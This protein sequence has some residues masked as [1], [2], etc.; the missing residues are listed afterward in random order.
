MK[1]K[2]FSFK[3]GIHP[4]YYKEFTKEKEIEKIEAPS[5][6]EIPLVQ[7]IGAPAE[8]L[9]K[10]GDVVKMGQMI[11][12]CSGVVSSN[13]HASVSGKVLAVAPRMQAVGM[14][15]TVVIENDGKDERDSG[16]Q[17]V[18]SIDR[19][20]TDQIISLIK[21]AGIVGMGGATFPTHVKL[22]PPKEHRIDT[23]IINGAECEPYLTSDYRLMV[24]TPEDIVNGGRVLIKVL[25]ISKAYIGIED[26]KPEAIEAIEQIIQN[27]ETMEVVALKTK[28]PQGGEKQLIKAVTSREVP[29]GKLPSSIGCV[30][31]NAGTVA[32]ICKAIISGMPLI[33]RVVTVTGAGI[34]NPK[35]LLVRLGTPIKQVIEKC[36]GL[37]PECKELISGGPMMGIT[38][39]TLDNSVTKGTSGILAIQGKDA[40]VGKESACI[41]CA[42]CIDVCPMGLMPLKILQGI[43]GGHEDEAME[44]SIMDCIECGCCSFICPAK[45]PILQYIRTGKAKMRLKRN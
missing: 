40:P 44:F 29:S 36:G 10:A 22:N 32:A 3:G 26:N 9:V 39:Y 16:I 18:T 30:V 38:Q 41:K 13:V 19:L 34:K 25:G 4:T 35:N 17:S 5:I 43:K 1:R 2:V 14:V 11:G 27:D 15:Q 31:I 37:T 6:M 8:S 7:H 45:R 28:Y 24:E 33:E 23:L 42:R 20:T 12:A 21:D